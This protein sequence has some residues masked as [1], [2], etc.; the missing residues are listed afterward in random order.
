MCE[1]VFPEYID[2]YNTLQVTLIFGTIGTIHRYKAAFALA[3]N[4][5]ITSSLAGVEYVLYFI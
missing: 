5:P 2:K 4:H 1:I 3:W